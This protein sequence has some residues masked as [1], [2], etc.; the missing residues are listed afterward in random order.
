MGREEESRRGGATVSICAS[1]DSA[2]MARGREGLPICGFRSKMINDVFVLSYKR[3]CIPF[4]LNSVC[5][6]CGIKTKHLNNIYFYNGS[7]IWL[8]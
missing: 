4:A 2:A 3:C 5:R 6:S 7:V 8:F 1:L